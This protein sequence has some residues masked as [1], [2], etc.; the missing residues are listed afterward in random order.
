MTL[1]PLPGDQWDDEVDK[2]LSRMLPR[3]RRNPEDAGNALAVLVRHPRLT[4]AFL[5]F[6]VHLLFGSTL[7]PRLRELAI[8]RVAHRR[9]CAY[10]WQ[11]HVAMGAD[12]GLSPAEIEAARGACLAADP[13]DRLIL[14]AVDELDTK[15][16]LSEETWLA[17]GARF[18]DRQ[19]MDFVFTVGCY[20][21]LSMAFNTFGI[22]PDPTAG[23][24]KH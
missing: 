2:A 20:T 6:N 21:T 7:E 17:L 16:R 11:H 10:E 15:S 18:D 8:L 4:R 1:T 19:R 5:G 23:F 24:S 3:D 12:A 22:S 9:D 14:A 13:F